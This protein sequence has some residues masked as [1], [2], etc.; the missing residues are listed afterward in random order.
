MPRFSLKSLP[1]PDRLD[2]QSMVSNLRTAW[3]NFIKIDSFSTLSVTAAGTT[4]LTAINQSVF[5]DATLGNIVLTVPSAV[6][7]AG[8]TLSVF[9]TD[10]SNNTVTVDGNVLG[11]NG[12]RSRLILMSDGSTWRVQLIYEEGFFTG[13]LTDCTTAPTAVFYYVKNGKHVTIKTIATLRATSNT[14]ACTITGMP[15]HLWPGTTTDVGIA[16]VNDTALNYVGGISISTLGVMTL[17]Y[18]NTVSTRTTVFT[19]SGTKG[20]GLACFSYTLQ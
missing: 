5:V 17:F 18:Q 13:T 19:N 1:F 15:S 2:T 4:V 7:N 3:E 10:V 20:I 9:K 8:L 6:G 11:A 14:T 16:N 12:A